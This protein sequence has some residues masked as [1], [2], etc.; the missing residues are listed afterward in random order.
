MSTEMMSVDLVLTF[1]LFPPLCLSS[2]VLYNQFLSQVDFEVLRDRAQVRYAP[3]SDTGEHTI[4]LIITLDL[5][6]SFSV[7][8]SVVTSAVHLVHTRDH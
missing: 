4:D 1:N 6:T 5:V 3:I 7:R 8:L 2:G